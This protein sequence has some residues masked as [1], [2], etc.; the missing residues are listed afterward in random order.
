MKKIIGIDLGTTNSCVALVES[1]SPKVITNQEGSR[2]TPSV[3]AYDKDGNRLVGASARR[4][5]VVNPESTIYSVKRFM[6][7]RFNESK[8]E[9]KKVPYKVVKGKSGDCRISV[10]ST[11]SKLSAPEISA[12]ILQKLKR[13]AENYLGQEVTEAVITVPAYFNDAQRQATK[14]AGK[15]AGLEVKRIINEPTAAALAYGLDKKEEQKVAVYDL[16]GG[17]FDISILEISDGVVEVMSTNGDTHLGGDDIDQI[18]ID[19]LM[20][21]FKDDTGID[22]SSDSM[23]IQRVREA[24]EKAKIELSTAQQTEISL[25]FLTADSTGPKHLTAS[26]SRSKFEQMIEKFVSSTLVPVESALKDASLSTGDIDEII[27]VGGSTRIPSVRAAVEKHFG[28]TA[29]SSVNPDEVVALGAAVQAGVFSGDV[30]DVLL[31]DVTPLSL[32]IE[33]LGGVTTFLIDRNTTIPISKSEVFSTAA[34]NQSAVDIHVL[35]GE[36]KFA[37]DNRTLGKFQ[38]SGIPPAPRG[39]PQIEVKFD[40]D[41]NGILSVSAKDKATGKEQSIRIEGQGGLSEDEISKMVDDAKLAEEEDKAKLVEIESR[42]MLDGAVYQ[43]EKLLSENEEKLSESTVSNL[44]EA[45]DN[46]K[47]SLDKSE[48]LENAFKQ[49]QS[50]LH[51]ASTELYDTNKPDDDE[52]KENDVVDA[53]FETVEE[54]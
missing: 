5:A 42:N 6:G 19:W 51:A 44:R 18:L 30:T 41:A 13:E 17:T 3:V 12:Q 50:V 21:Q 35:Q 16:G 45:I 36:R 47:D 52:Q 27:L 24:S 9:I 11:G 26:L 54:E 23:V 46:A 15:I 37:N 8:D 53:D 48:D 31:L 22:V 20:K 29:N 25:P 14:D 43:S 4:Q 32:G 49:L 33:T 1:K 10:K 34:D 39:L 40:I 28:K 38:L 2:T 7:M